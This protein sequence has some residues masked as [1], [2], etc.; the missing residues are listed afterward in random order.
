[1]PIVYGMHPNPSSLLSSHPR[2][3][4]EQIMKNTPAPS[5]D[6]QLKWLEPAAINPTFRA[7]PPTSV[8]LTRQDIDTAQTD[9]T[10]A[11]RTS[12]AIFQDADG[13]ASSAVYLDQL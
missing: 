11:F 9:P 8:V 7:S 1:M 13:T 6:I 2:Q 12:V 5:S 10:D 4:N 3:K